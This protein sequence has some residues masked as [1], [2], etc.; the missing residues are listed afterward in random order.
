MAVSGVP[1]AVRAGCTESCEVTYLLGQKQ[2]WACLI[3]CDF[4]MARGATHVTG[5]HSQNCQLVREHLGISLYTALS[6]ST[7]ECVTWMRA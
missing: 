1:E 4:P 7:Q 6:H 2:G 5:L 3:K